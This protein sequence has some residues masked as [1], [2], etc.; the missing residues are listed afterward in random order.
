MEEH[1]IEIDDD[2][3]VR[4][5]RKFGQKRGSNP[6]ATLSRAQ[7]RVSHNY[8]D[9]SVISFKVYGAYGGKIVEAS[10]YNDKRDN[11]I[12]KLYIIDEN[13]DFAESLA[14]IVTLEYLR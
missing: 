7:Q 5:P 8:D 13:L 2:S 14:K 10:R 1:C 3:N 11:E 6:V 4:R 9:E 12:I